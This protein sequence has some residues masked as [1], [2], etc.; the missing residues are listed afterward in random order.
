[1]SLVDT[2]VPD[3]GDPA[4]LPHDSLSDDVIA[5]AVICV[6]FSVVS[7]G[8]RFYT[9]TRVLRVLSATDWWLLAALVGSC[10]QSAFFIRGAVNGLGRHIWDFKLED[11]YYEIQQSAWFCL[12]WYNTTLT[13]VKISFLLLYIQIFTYRKAGLVCKG[14]LVLVIVA[15]LYGLGVTF[16]NCIPLRASWD[17]SVVGAYCHDTPLWWVNT[18]LHV[19]TDF[20]IW[21]VPIPQIWRMRMP[22]GQKMT[23]ISLFSLGF[24]VAFISFIR[25]IFLDELHREK[26]PDFTYA[27]AH[28]GYF[29]I[30]EVNAGITVAGIITLKPLAHRLFPKMLRANSLIML[31]GENPPTIGTRPPGV[32]G[33]RSEGPAGAGTM[34]V[35]SWEMSKT[36]SDHVEAIPTPTSSRRDD[37][38]V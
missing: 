7:V 17:L 31:P 12:L 13:L 10:L 30:I 2:G 11:H 22:K 38:I 29:S 15:G 35:E 33:A 5:C 9:R 21:S 25:I 37:S 14:M 26:D 27:G 3:F 16:T 36:E 1:M 28:F 24:V 23:L 18:S 4:D 19:F 8:L 20:A 34:A 32:N 6:A